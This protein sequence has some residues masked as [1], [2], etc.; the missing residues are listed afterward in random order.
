MFRRFQTVLM[1]LTLA[2]GGNSYGITFGESSPSTLNA[3]NEG[4]EAFHTYCDAE[5]SNAK[6]KLHSLLERSTQ[7]A[8][9]EFL[10]AYND[11]LVVTS[12]LSAQSSLFSNVHPV[13]ELRSAAEACDQK[14]S[15]LSTEISLHQQLYQAFQSLSIE[16]MDAT[17]K[18]FVAHEL[19]DFRRA[20]VDKDEATR[21][22]ITK[23][24]DE[25]TA[26]G[27]DFGRNI[28]EDVR[29]V[30]VESEQE[31]AGL[32]ADYIAMRQPGPNGKIRI[33]TDYPDYIPVMQ[34]AHNDALREKLYRQ[35][36]TRA[37]PVNIDVLERMVQKRHELARLLGYRSWAAY[38]TEDKMIKTETRVAEFIDE[39]ASTARARGLKDY[40]EILAAKRLVHPEAKV[41]N[42]WEKL[43]YSEKV[44]A[45]RY[46]YDPQQL[47]QFFEFNKVENG[48]L[49][50]SEQLF[51][52]QFVP[53]PN[54]ET[55]HSQVR[56][57][58]V[59]ENGKAIGRIFL[60]MHPR[61]GKYKHAAQF[62]LRNGVA[63]KQLPEGV[64]V[65]NFPDPSTSDV[66]L[67]EHDDVSTYFHEFGHLLHHVF[68]G[69]QRWLSFSG[70]ATE[71]DFVEAPSQMFEEWAED[72]DVLKQFA[73]HHKTGEVI[74]KELVSR[75]RKAKSFGRGEQMSQQMFYAALSL[76]LYNRDPALLNSTELLKEMQT[77]YSVYPYV[78]GTYFQASFGHLDGY[79]AIYY[80]Y[81]WSQAIARDLLSRF[82]VKGGQKKLLDPKTT[83]LYRKTILD[84]GGSK[85]AADLVADFLGRPYRFDA[86]KQWLSE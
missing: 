75:L 49:R 20:G 64:L 66:A 70:V 73:K 44:R 77:K 10:E 78:E 80:T 84:P 27:Q 54:V 37:H 56:V 62:T 14:I 57:F 12:N 11:L 26:I 34:Y 36:L 72:Y 41:V 42:A 16:G 38:V 22:R 71:W 69:Q 61:E 28:R 25:I 65:C 53:N 51:G 55:W 50:L 63:G 48:I 23:L 32:P 40:Q 35:F 5:I 39:V 67:M 3:R 1:A 19:R 9:I 13:E 31:L 15:A 17:T 46:A 79:S 8:A 59:M 76:N 33:T 43:Y 74:P 68:G 7:L 47:R 85:D 6:S 86:F 81:A 30:E 60:D 21:T 52:V 82:T 18:R 58:D 4:A 29:F 24:R 2:S 83:A 45:Q